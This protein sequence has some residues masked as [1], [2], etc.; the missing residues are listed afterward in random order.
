MVM[1]GVLAVLAVLAIPVAVVVLLVSVSRLKERVSTFWSAG[2]CWIWPNGRLPLTRSA[3][4]RRGCARANIGR[5]FQSRCR[6]PSR[7]NRRKSPSPQPPLR[8]RRHHRLA[9]I[10]GALRPPARPRC[11]PAQPA[12]SLWPDAARASRRLASSQLGLRYFG[13]VAGA[14]RHLLRPVRGGAWLAA[15]GSP[16]DC[17]DHLRPCA[18]RRRRMVPPPLGRPGGRCNRLSALHLLE[19]RGSCRSSAASL[20]R[21]SFMA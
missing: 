4:R 5:W 19:A 1:L 8:P 17:G 13:A 6:S 20:P 2:P 21:A 7:P 3:T 14:R 10:P 15:A 9:A 18:D 12:P 16:G 11:R